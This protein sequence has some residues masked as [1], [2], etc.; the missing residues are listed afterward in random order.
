MIR[1]L[2]QLIRPEYRIQAGLAAAK[3]LLHSP[4]QKQQ[5]IACYAALPSEFDC[6]PIIEALWQTEKHCYLPLIE[7]RGNKELHFGLYRSGD[8]L[9]RNHYQVLE[10][11]DPKEIRTAQQLDL[12]LLP[13]LAFDQAGYRLGTGGGY[14]DHTFSFLLQQQRPSKPL[15]FGLAYE[16]QTVDQLPHESFDVPLDGVITEKEV[17][18]F[19]IC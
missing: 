16:I 12:V 17:R 9:R 1:P 13:L 6:Q 14:Y 15:L 4:F 19:N 8:K 10:P 2:R 18:E 11:E 5:H 7:P 3:L